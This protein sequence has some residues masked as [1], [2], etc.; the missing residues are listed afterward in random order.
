MSEEIAVRLRTVREAL[1]ETH[2]SI[3]LRL[4]MGPNTWRECEETGRLPKTEPLQKLN[5]LGFSIDWLLT[6]RR[7]MKVGDVAEMPAPSPAPLDTPTLKAVL[8]A[9][10][11]FAQRE[12]GILKADPGALLKWMMET[13]QLISAA[14]QEERDQ[15]AAEITAAQDKGVA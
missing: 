4:G 1:G 6:G 3:S 13:Y 11:Q 12:P 9:F 14:P 15:R 7:A 2:R 8:L 5:A 10:I